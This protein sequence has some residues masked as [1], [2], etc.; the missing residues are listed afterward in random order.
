MWELIEKKTGTGASGLISWTGL[1]GDV[2]LIYRLTGLMEPSSSDFFNILPNGL[3]TNLDGEYWSAATGS[4]AEAN[5]TGGKIGPASASS[6]LIDLMFYADKSGT[7]QRSIMWTEWVGEA[8]P[9]MLIG[10]TSW[11]ESSTNLTSLDIATGGATNFTTETNLWLYKLLE[12][13]G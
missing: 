13:A 10:G 2:D 8:N 11:E 5:T 4:W 1:D 12:P 7:Q 9:W 3:G 6:R